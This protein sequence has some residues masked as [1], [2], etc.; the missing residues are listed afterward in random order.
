MVCSGDSVG[1]KER[2]MASRMVARIRRHVAPA[3]NALLVL[4]VEMLSW[5]RWPRELGD[6]L[7][8]LEYLAVWCAEF[9]EARGM[10][11]G[12]S[13]TFSRRAAGRYCLSIGASRDSIVVGALSESEK[14]CATRQVS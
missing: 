11:K 6:R 7:S 8:I 9:D 5:R 13:S 4:K 10:E 12:K 1:K 14:S 2:D 3:R